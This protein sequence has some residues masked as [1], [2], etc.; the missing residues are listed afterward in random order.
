MAAFSKEESLQHPLD[1]R[2]LQNAPVAIYRSAAIL[3]AD[4]VTL[5]GLGYRVDRIDLAKCN[6]GQ[7]FYDAM[8]A[9]LEFPSFFG[10]NRNAFIDV[11]RDLDIPEQGG[12][13]I[14]FMNAHRFPQS[15]LADLVEDLASTARTHLLLGKRL[16]SIIQTDRKD[17]QFEATSVIALLNP[18][19][20]WTQSQGPISE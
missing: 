15:E 17:Q 18:R 20:A 5:A 8:S 9:A 2:L 4:L 12:R 3:E 16:I 1:F 7:R 6:S 19:E 14:V 10:R 13:V 11:M